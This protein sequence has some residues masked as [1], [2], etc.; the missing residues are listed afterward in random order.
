MQVSEATADFFGVQS[1]EEI[2]S[3]KGCGGNSMNIRY[4]DETPR[5]RTNTACSAITAISVNNLD[6]ARPAKSSMRVACF[7]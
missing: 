2:R 3:L 5:T 6:E 1:V 4:R 7:H